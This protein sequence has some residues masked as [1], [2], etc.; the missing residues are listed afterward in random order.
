VCVPEPFA[1]FTARRYTSSVYNA[2]VVSVY[3]S[4]RPS[5]Y[6]SLAGIVS[7]QLDRSS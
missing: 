2:V 3:P 5:V 1:V 7:K 4:V 6:V